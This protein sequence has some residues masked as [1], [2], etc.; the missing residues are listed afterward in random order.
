ML[1]LE[2]LDVVLLIG[3]GGL[4]GVVNTLAGG[5]SFLTVPLLIMLG[6]PGSVA[7]GTNR[8]G[9]LLQCGTALWRFRSEGQLDLRRGLPVLVP[10]VIGSW[11]GASGIARLDATA[12][13]R[14]FGAVM[15]VLLIPTL[16]GSRARSPPPGR[17]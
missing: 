11:I 12:F 10:V 13:E 14:V 7:N 9:V 4:A 1:D 3:G 17:W 16:R 8:V 2:A 5:G 15:L 6:L